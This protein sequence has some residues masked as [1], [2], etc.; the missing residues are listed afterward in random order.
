M[1]LFLL[2]L[3]CVRGVNF[4][5][6]L[7]W[8]IWFSIS[9]PRASLPLYIPLLLL[10]RIRLADRHDLSREKRKEKKKRSWCDDKRPNMPTTHSTVLAGPWLR[11]DRWGPTLRMWPTSTRGLRTVKKKN[12]KVLIADD[13]DEFLQIDLS[14]IIIF[15]I[16]HHRGTDDKLSKRCC[17]FALWTTFS[18]CNKFVLTSILSLI[19]WINCGRV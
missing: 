12:F 15:P 5:F 2:F 16:L 3:P 10:Y 7:S 19:I 13:R 8:Y 11:R 6:Q 17:T 1:P 18:D 9:S 14:I 4:N